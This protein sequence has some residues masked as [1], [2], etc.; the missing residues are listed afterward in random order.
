MTIAVKT[1]DPKIA[2]TL[3]ELTACQHLA[4]THI[5]FSLTLNCP[6]RCAH[7]IVDAGP[8]KAATTMPLAVAAR[9]GAQMPALARHGIRGI[10]FTGG[11]P[12]VARA[13]LRVMS[14]AAAAAGIDVSVVTAAQ[15]AATPDRA[16]GLVAQFPAISC[17]DIS[18]DAHHLPWVD[19]HHIRNAV[20]ALRAAGRRA[21]IRVTY[22]DPMTE[23]DRRIMD[24]LAAIGEADC[25][26]QALRP[27]G[28]GEDL[29]AP[30][31]HGWSPWIKPCLTQGMVVRYD[32][33]VSPCCLNLVESRAHPFR[34]GAPLVE[35][36]VQVHR[37]F[38][39]D[40][41]LQLI[42][43]LGFGPLRDWIEAEGLA[44]LLPD[45]VPEEVC[46]LCTAIMHRPE[47]ARLVQAR[48]AEGEVPAKIAV[49]AAKVLGETDMLR[50]VA[51]DI[52]SPE[53]ESLP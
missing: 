44:H 45:P 19:I 50:A 4:R 17:W 53:P 16:A 20:T 9:Y 30:R 11:E 13:P 1:P 29:H 28:R 12:L 22:S 33:S 7:C 10:C 38:L 5:T 15:W 42:R 43:A 41:L 26:A 3:Q 51:P 31:P 47:L 46:E 32:G 6:L 23:A 40:P 35:D 2:L 34:F 21:N 49:I 39:T 25:V 37:R 27:V 36:L 14:E 18:F 52:L 24:D 48:A 8:D